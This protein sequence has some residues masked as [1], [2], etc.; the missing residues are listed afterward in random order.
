MAYRS[1][2][3]RFLGDL[4][5]AMVADAAPRTLRALGSKASIDV[6][7]VGEITF[8]HRLQG[9]TRMEEV[10]AEIAEAVRGGVER[11]QIYSL[12]GLSSLGGPSGTLPRPKTGLVESGDSSKQP[13]GVWKRFKV[14]AFNRA[15]RLLLISIRD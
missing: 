3:E 11:I 9:M 10:D 15:L 2:Y 5:T 4:G 7:V 6:G 1:E 12:D 14:W 13:R 8:P